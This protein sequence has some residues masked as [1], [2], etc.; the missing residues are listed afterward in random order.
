[1]SWDVME[2]AARVCV[3]QHLHLQTDE[4][5]LPE[6]RTFHRKPR[7]Q[8]NSRLRH[9]HRGMV[10]R[11]YVRLRAASTHAHEMLEGHMAQARQLVVGVGSAIFSG[12]AL[13]AASATSM[14]CTGWSLHQSW[15]RLQQ[16]DDEEEMDIAVARY[17]GAYVPTAAARRSNLHRCRIQ[18]ADVPVL[19]TLEAAP[20]QSSRRKLLARYS[21][22]LLR[23]PWCAPYT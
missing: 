19:G 8:H 21:S 23:E 14:F 9:R 2:Q 22:F 18:A 16:C 10:L 20:Q 5:V 11:R 13:I 3:G 4:S 17:G 6:H 12:E 7:R 1:M 15:S